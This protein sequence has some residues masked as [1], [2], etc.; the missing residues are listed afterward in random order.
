MVNI[1]IQLSKYIIIVLMAAYTFS[2]F[3]IFTRNYEDEEKRVLI[4]QDV[5]LFLLQ[6]AA[7]GTMYLATEDM[8]IL[9][10]YAALAV[11]SLAIILLYNL[12]YPN[13]SRLVINNMCMLITV[14]MVMITRLSAD[15]GSPYGTAIRQL[16]FVVLGITFG[17]I[18]PVLIRKLT[19][20]DSWT[21]IYAAVGGAALLAVAL[22]APKSG[23]ANLGFEIAGLNIQP[24]EFVK[25]LFVFYVAA[26]LNKSKEFKNIVVTTAVAA[27]HVLILV[28]S[29]DLGAA[30]IFFVVYLVMLYVATRQPLYAVA[31][32]GAGVL[33]AVAGYHLFSHIKVRVEAWQDPI[34]T[35][36]GSGY[37]VA[38]SLFAIGTGSWFG[39]G[40]FQGQPDTIP[41]AE[42]DFIFS[43]ITEEM[44][45]IFSLC[46]ILICVSCYVM[47]LNIA[48]ELHN[49]FYKY[50]A[51]GLGTCYIF[52]VFLQIGGV[53][54]FI[55]STGMTLPFVSY[56]G[57]SMLSTMIMFGIIQGL[58]IVRED[59]EEQ[60]EKEK[61][62]ELR[63]GLGRTAA[64]KTPKSA[65]RFE[66][67]P[68]QRT[69]KKQ[70]PRTK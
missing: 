65:P 20:L 33:A 15:N 36:S 45:V 11:V 62:R 54:K 67:V 24:S 52:Q 42:T 25:I 34:G 29:T 16:I 61:E 49:T 69:R 14:G 17:L 3:S 41:V 19:F 55:P 35:Y 63:Y 5:L 8:R 21:Y 59:E 58:Y 64:G 31:G 47:F 50:V 68:R 13:V 48:M 22:F 18:V 7:F 30:L 43:A 56:G 37:Q 4:R 6:I 28:L 39:T 44:G 26:S 32:L 40:L 46:I 1:I 27:A 38:Q 53:T 23:G 70:R 60:I 57:S 12:I 9:F 2:C 51:L 10:L 66:E